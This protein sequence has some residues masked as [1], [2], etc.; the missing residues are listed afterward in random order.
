MMY[1]NYAATSYKRP[2]CVIDAV[3]KAM[4]GS[5]N[6]GRGSS[7]VDLG[8]ARTAYET[9]TELAKLF[10]F[11]Y[12]ERVVFSY[13]A[14]T[15]LNQA[16]L[17]LLNYGDHVIATDWDHNSVIRPLNYASE[18]G[19]LVDYIQANANGKLRIEDLD[20]LIR[21]NT[22]LVIC[23]H[24]SNVTGDVADIRK[25]TA[26]AHDH[27]IP[28]LVDAS[29]TAGAY[30]INMEKDGIDILVFTGHKSLM[31][32]T[33]TGGMCVGSNIDI[34]AVIRGGTGIQSLNPLQP[35][36]YPEHLEAGTINI[37]GIAG[38]YA[39]VRYIANIGAEN[40]RQKELTLANRFIMGIRD[41]P[42][43]TIYGSAGELSSERTSVVSMNISGIGADEVGDI[44]TNR[45]DIAVRTG[46]HCAP[47]MHRALGTDRTGTVRFSFGLFNTEYE[48][49]AAIEAVREI[50]EMA[51]NV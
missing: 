19:T 1:F 32:P 47:R 50:S 15:S 35:S 21:S 4:S 22:K 34:A 25:I 37:H 10:G 11:S 42:G 12:P 6:A 18:R 3:I 29:Q 17:G 13:N 9:R 27:G 36:E 48:I 7:S 45:F 26:V 33:G 30:P 23:T 20:G 46:I 38:L 8:S 39:A 31:G 44:L 43:I 14:T 16:I 28:V 40:I 5:G 41:I 49:D 24:A 2:D 51:G